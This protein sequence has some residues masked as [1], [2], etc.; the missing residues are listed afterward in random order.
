M[1]FSFNWAGVNIPKIDAQPKNAANEIAANLGKAQWGS[2]VRDANNEY[3]DMLTSGSSVAEEVRKIQAEIARL[4]ARNNE[5]RRQQD[6]NRANALR[7]QQEENDLRQAQW[8]SDQAAIGMQGYVPNMA[9]YSQYMDEMNRRN[10]Y[11]QGAAGM[12]A[13]LDAQ[14]YR[15]R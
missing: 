10:Q 14:H 6:L 2:V 3:A 11:M 15:T 5:I 1:A 8:N 7:A 12:L 9:G 13:A 4:E